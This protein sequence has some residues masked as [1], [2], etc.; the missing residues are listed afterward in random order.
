MNVDGA[1]GESVEMAAYYVLAEALANAAKHSAASGVRVSVRCEGPN[2]CMVIR[3]DGVGGAN[4][5][6]LI[7]LPQRVRVGGSPTCPI[8]VNRNKFRV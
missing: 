8:V 3:D 5:D 4:P 7:G 2:L 1:V 6:P